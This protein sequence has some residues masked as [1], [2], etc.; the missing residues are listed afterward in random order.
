MLLGGILVGCVVEN[1]ASELDA[2]VDVAAGELVVITCLSGSRVQ[3]LHQVVHHRRLVCKS[4][5]V[6]LKIRNEKKL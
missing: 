6:C 4:N 2:G 5:H 3:A 1:D